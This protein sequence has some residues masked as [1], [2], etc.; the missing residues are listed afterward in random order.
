VVFVVAALLAYI[1][2]KVIWS[3]FIIPLYKPII[4][5]EGVEGIQLYK[6]VIVDGELWIS[7]VFALIVGAGAAIATQFRK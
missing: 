7:L 5:F 2:F 3:L 4:E 6:N 1:S